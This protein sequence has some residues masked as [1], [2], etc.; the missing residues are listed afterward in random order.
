M[1]SFIIMKTNLMLKT[2][3]TKTLWERRKSIIFWCVGVMAYGLLL[4]S[5]FPMFGDQ[6]AYSQMLTEMDLPPAFQAFLGE[7]GDITTPA[8]FLAVEHFNHMYIILMLILAVGFANSI[9]A[10]EEEN[11]TLELVLA[12]PISRTSFLLQKIAALYKVVI[13]VGL[14]SWI[15]IILGPY[16]VDVELNNANIFW[17]TLS[18]AL[19]ALVFGNLSLCI[20]A[21]K[22]NRGLATALTSMIFIASYFLNTFSLAVD[23]LEPYQELSILYYYNVNETLMHGVNYNYIGILLLLGL[24]FIPVTLWAFRKRDVGV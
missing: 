8:G 3:Y 16:V 20:T 4:I 22:N 24:A 12:R 18:G 13:L 23:W 19:T 10:K 21:F 6:T 2:I 17:A 5:L 1:C 15:G 14:A 9:I 11:G 7:L